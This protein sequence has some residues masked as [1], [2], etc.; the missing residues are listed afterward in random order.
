LGGVMVGLN[1]WATAPELDYL[2]SHSDTTV[3]ITADRYLKYDY[4]AM[5]DAIARP[6][7]LREIVVL[8][9]ATR[10]GY[11]R[12][13][14]LMPLAAGVPDAAID[15]AQRAVAPGDLA[16]LLYTS[17]STARPKGVQL[18]HHGL[19][20]NMWHIGERLH[21]TGD[22]RLWLAVSM[23]WGFACENALVAILTHGGTTGLQEHFDAGDPIAV[24]P[25]ERCTI[26]YRTANLVEAI[27]EH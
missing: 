26:F 16:Y 22:D 24:V 25:R 18:Q 4:L 14:D 19:I 7:A 1:T 23:F 6:P 9:A 20:E 5:L 11:R 21:L 12:Y 2:L 3:L 17:G 27:G 8:G 15:A 10:P 13:E